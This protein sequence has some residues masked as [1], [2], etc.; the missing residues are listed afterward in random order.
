MKRYNQ[1]NEDIRLPDALR[2]RVLAE[3][4]RLTPRRAVV[5]ATAAALILAA[6]SVGAAFA[7][8]GDAPDGVPPIETTAVPGTTAAPETTAPPADTTVPSE[9]QQIEG[10]LPLQLTEV[11][12]PAA[13]Q[14]YSDAWRAER[15][16]RISQPAGYDS[17]LHTLS[18]TLMRQF[19]I[20]SDRTA[21][22][23]R[24]ISPIN[25][26]FALAMLTEVTDTT[27]RSALL[28]LLGADS[29]DVLREQSASVWTANYID[30]GTS[31]TRLASSLWLANNVP[32]RRTTLDH[33]ADHYYTSAFQGKMGSDEMNESLRCWLNAQTGGLLEEQTGGL[34]FSP[35]TILALATTIYYDAQWE[36]PFDEKNTSDGV[37]HAAAGD[38][39]VPFMHKE[40]AAHH[41]FRCEGYT[42][43]RMSFGLSGGS[44]LLVLPDEGVTPDDLFAREDVYTMIRGGWGKREMSLVNLSMPR[45]DVTADL[46][47]TEGLSALGLGELFDPSA[48]DFSPITT[49]EALADELC[50]TQAR[51]AIRVKADEEGCR[52][53]A[54][55]FVIVGAMGGPIEIVDFILDRP[56]IFVI[57]S[58]TGAPL[59]AGVVE[60]P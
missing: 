15:Q 40:A 12:Y 27:S 31:A 55:T 36:E 58:D 50:L 19:L 41:L 10:M 56:F 43:L 60:Q 28:D 51:H 53:A 25:L 45:F 57:T 4:K 59:F 1:A 24:V 5:L 34:S 16:T 9:T 32:F 11:A 22:Q 37:F 18:R 35:N 33:L 44:M 47:L 2:S 38:V 8:R 42:A 17:G 3:T 23:N 52:A 39:I 49:D 14:Y 54:Y 30:D 26:Y 29:V 48:A 20:S 21:G 7:R 46:D 13:A 6:V